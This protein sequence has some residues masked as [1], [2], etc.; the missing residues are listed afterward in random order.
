MERRIALAFA[1]VGLL[2]P[3]VAR[4][5]DAPDEPPPASPAQP[6]PQEPPP[7]P[8]VTAEPPAVAVGATP[9]ETNVAADTGPTAKPNAAAAPKPR[10]FAGSSLFVTN[11]VTTNTI[12][13]GQTQ[14]YDPTVEASLWLLPRYAI[15]DAFQLR[16]RAIVSYELTNSDSSTYRNEPLLSDV[17]AQLFYRKIPLLPGGIKPSVALNVAVPT[18][19][20]SRSRT[21]IFTPGATVQ[22]ARPFEKILGGDGMLLGSLA[23]SHPFYRS[24]N[25]EVV[26]PRPPGAFQCLGGSGCQ[27]LASGTMNPSD[28]LSYSLLF[29]MQW[30]PFNPA[31]YYQ[32]ASQ[33]TYHPTEATN[34]VDGTPIGRPDGFVPTSVRQTHYFSAWLDYDFNP[35]LTGEVGFWNSI[36]ALDESGQHA[37]LIFSRYQ[38]TRVYLGA[39]IQLD[40]LVRAMQGTSEGDGGIVRAKNS[41]QPMW[42][43]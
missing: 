33:W 31:I 13:R 9:A 27:D 34:P 25:A 3:A 36:S 17:S 22:L 2:V 8:P 26:D 1:L 19:K 42:S 6:Q 40:N 39:S 12:F 41:K 37:N 23:Y 20:V 29:D 16:A 15:N 38:D 30:G 18:S 32:G 10:P 14:Y 21:M 28:T 5:Q 35:W 4:A 43:F 11:S 24:K 7:P